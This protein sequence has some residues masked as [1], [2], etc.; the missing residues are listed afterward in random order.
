MH[1]TWAQV[2]VNRQVCTPACAPFGLGA[3]VFS[4]VSATGM[5]QAWAR[6]S[7]DHTHAEPYLCK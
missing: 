3:S 1:T 7:A 2:H 6:C 5:Q 4:G